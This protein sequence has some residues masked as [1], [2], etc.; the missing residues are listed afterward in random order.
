MATESISVGTSA[1]TA[2]TSVGTSVATAS[3][4]AATDL[5]SGSQTPT[6]SLKNFFDSLRAPARSEL[7]RERK[8]RV[9]APP[10]TGARKKAPTCTTNPKGVSAAQR[11]KEFSGE[12]ITVSAGRLFCSACREE[13]SLK[14]SVVT[15]HVGSAKHVQQK[16]QL[17]KNQSRERDIAKALQTYEQEIHPSGET[18][19]EAQKLY[20]VK[21]VTAFLKAGIPIGKVEHFKDLLEEHAFMLCDH[22]GMS[23]LIPFVQAE[24]KQQIKAELQGKKVSV[25]FDGTIYLAWRSTSYNSL[26][27]I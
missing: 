6:P 13:L 19:P 8:V 18:L 23:D 21:V 25:I 24:E 2:S 15:N 22:C 26:I 17:G 14:R 9:N 20:R 11:A 1:A 16:K 5:D 12:M 10:H 4:S 7:M 3:T 27:C